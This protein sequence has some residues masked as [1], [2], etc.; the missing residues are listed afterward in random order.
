MLFTLALLLSFPTVAF[1]TATNGKLGGGDLTLAL[2]LSFPTVAFCTATN[3][4]LGGGDL[5]TRL[6]INHLNYLTLT[7][8]RQGMT[9]GG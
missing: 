3:G 9:E 5:E 6:Q 7:C 2:L 4:K 8:Y 1:C